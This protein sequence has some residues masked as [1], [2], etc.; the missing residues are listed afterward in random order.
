MTDVENSSMIFGCSDRHFQFKSR[1]HQIV[2]FVAFGVI[3]PGSYHVLE[4]VGSQFIQ[5]HYHTFIII[6]Y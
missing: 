4:H 5:P 1:P 2:Q 6:I 3:Y